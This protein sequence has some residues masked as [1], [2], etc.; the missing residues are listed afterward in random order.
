M[1]TELSKYAYQEYIPGE[2]P[3]LGRWKDESDDVWITPK[4]AYRLSKKKIAVIDE[5]INEIEEE[6]H[7]TVEIK[8]NE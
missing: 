3:Y 1:I 6:L 2:N 8:G 7:V 4:D 5:A